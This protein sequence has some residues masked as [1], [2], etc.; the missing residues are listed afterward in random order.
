MFVLNYFPKA[1]KDMQS[2][3]VVLSSGISDIP[4]SDLTAVDAK[5]IKFLK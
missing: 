5:T 4:G 3:R 1:D 2:S